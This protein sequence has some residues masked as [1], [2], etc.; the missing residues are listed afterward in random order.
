VSALPRPVARG[1]RGAAATGHPLATA[2]ALR[3]YDAG[4]TA[5]DAALAAAYVLFVV[6]PDACGVGG[7]ALITIRAGSGELVSFNG[8][9]AS[10]RGFV[11]TVPDDG[12]RTTAVPGAVAALAA[13]HERYGVLDVGFLLEPAVRLAR[14]GFAVHES[15][16]ASLAR[17]R[18]R[19]ERRADGFELLRIDPAA[20]RLLRQDALAGVIEAIGR[21]GPAVFYAGPVAEAVQA[22]A[23]EDGAELCAP[24]LASHQTVVTDP[25]AIGFRG[26]TVYGQPPVAQAVLGLMTLRVLDGL[27]DIDPVTRHHV[28]IEA[29][30]AAFTHRDEIADPDAGAALL[31]VD[32]AVD[33]ERAR[34]SGGPTRQAH[35]TAVACAD[36]TGTVV[37]MVVSV[38]DEFGCSRLVT[39]YGFLLNNRMMCFS[40]DPASPNAV[41]PAK[42]PVH[43]LSPMLLDNVDIVLALSTPGADGQ[44][45]TLTQLLERMLVDGVSPTAALDAP[46]WRSADGGLTIEEGFSPR[47]ANALARRGH[48]LSWAPRG[49]DAFGAAVLA[50]FEPHTGSV[51]AAAD[52]RRD[53]WAGAC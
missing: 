33:R 46:R 9:G 15:L 30:N 35:T 18:A 4:G 3:A 34:A 38:F 10:P 48:A 16:L 14:E 44:V 21:D 36:G 31:D 42:R 41:G 51:F 12:A 53:A 6:M 37:T 27:E 1:R 25:L 22:A 49:G 47:V 7:D 40:P 28:A 32:L 45:Q 13:A 11:G 43:T 8:S 5:F 19:L 17:Q 50:G 29:L 20:G 2:A 23:R 24:D 26:A 39:P 52:L